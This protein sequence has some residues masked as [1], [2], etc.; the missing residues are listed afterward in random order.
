ME[1]CSQKLEEV[2]EIFANSEKAPEF[3][4]SALAEDIAKREKEITDS[5]SE[6]EA[7]MPYTEPQHKLFEA[8]AHD[9]AIAAKHNIPQAKAAELAH[10]GVKK[11]DAQKKAIKV[12]FKK[13]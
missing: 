3:L 11:D 6:K 2:R 12:R 9:P 8:A 4:R 7:A 5:Q 13:H 10:E 1:Q